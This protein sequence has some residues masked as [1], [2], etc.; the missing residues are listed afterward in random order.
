MPWYSYPL[1]FVAGLSAGAINTLAG[2][3]SL[4]TLPL[5]I[6]FGLPAG[7]ANGTNRVAILLQNVVGSA[8][9]RSQGVLDSRGAAWLS[10]PAVVGAI[11]GAQIAVDLNETV[12]RQV[13]GVIMIAM[14]F[15]VILQPHK[16]LEGELKEL[17]GRPN[18][19]SLI[20]FFF[21]GLYGGF[22]QAGVGIF[23]LSGLVLLVGYDIVRA[24]AVK[25][26]IVLFFTLFA[27]IVF[28]LN[29][30]VDWGVG[31]VLASGNMLGAWAAARMAVE[32]GS[33]WVMRI[34]VAT[35]AISAAYLLGFFEWLSRL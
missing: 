17:T 16:W 29:N 20:A 33:V 2:S 11:I 30:Q 34:L 7:I 24:N 19:K 25:V 22:I 9:Y 14:L 5:L 3:G 27:L 1:I 32:K 4:I 28:I 12:L 26:L 6:F 23:L 8:S 18:T 10:A 31:L 21:I 35:L 15:I 13:I